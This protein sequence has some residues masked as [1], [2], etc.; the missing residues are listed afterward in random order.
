MS[1][2]KKIVI[3]AG[4]NG[5]GKTTFAREFLPN[6]AGC[7]VF[8]NADLIAA[9]LSP[10]RPEEVVFRAGRL[11]L[12]EIAHHAASGRSFAF[13]TTLSGLTYARMIDAWR[14]DGYTV[15]LIFLSLPS[16][17]VAIARVAMRVRQGGHHVP[18]DTIRRRFAAGLRHFQERYR[19]RVDFWQLFDNGGDTPLLLEEGAHA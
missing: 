14:F 15:K 4:P 11:M 6:E 1:T 8:V 16:P 17:E 7:P 10:F 19:H 2:Q 13:E 3:I 5:A 9:G 12:A 18:A